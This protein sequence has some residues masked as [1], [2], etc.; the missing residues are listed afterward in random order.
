MAFKMPPMPILATYSH[1]KTNKVYAVMGKAVNC[2]NSQEGQTMVMYMAGDF[3]GPMFVREIKEFVEKFTL[4]V[5]A[6]I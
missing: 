1:N 2:T 3:Q 4:L 5:G 6:S